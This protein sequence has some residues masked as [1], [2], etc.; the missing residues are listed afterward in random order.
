MRLEV[1]LGAALLP[2]GAAGG[3]EAYPWITSV[4]ALRVVARAGDGWAGE[5][6]QLALELDN[7]G[8]QASRLLRRSHRSLANVYRDDGSLYFRGTVQRVDPGRAAFILT[9]ESGGAGQLLSEPLPMRTTR[10]LGDYATAVPIPQ[11]YGDLSARRFRLIRLNATEYLAAGHPMT[12]LDVYVDDEETAAYELDLL[13]DD[14]G[15]VSQLVRFAAPLGTNQTASATGTGKRN[16]RTG[17]LIENPADL[18]EDVLAQAGVTALFPLLRQQAAAEGLRLAGSITEPRT[19]RAIVDEIMASAGAIWTPEFARLYP[20]STIAGPIHE[21]DATAAGGMDDPYSDLE[22]TADVLRVAYDFSEAADRPQHHLELSASPQR[23]GGLAAELELPWVWLPANAES[24][25]SRVLG[26]KAGERYRL[27]R[28][29]V[30]RDD[31]RPGAAVRLV[32]VPEWAVDDSD[33]VVMVL[34]VDVD[35]NTGA[36]RIAGETVLSTPAIRV[37]AVSI[38]LPD[39][40]KGGVDVRIVNG[41]ATFTALDDDGKPL[42]GA[43][44]TLD[45]VGPRTVNDKGEA[46]FAIVGGKHLLVIEREGFGLIE[47]E[48]DS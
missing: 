33:P 26:F 21:L 18:A 13:R 42:Y 23:Y 46:S 16:P 28:I 39:T 22:D 30:N 48:F 45:G 35:G 8:G 9:L 6:A 34:S 7:T 15:N 36:T 17:A 11:R 24:I 41:L 2:F 47:H 43:R 31:L 1:Q 14:A 5:T 37:T 32:D 4:G 3:T 25:G 10:E 40:T 19:V 44:M 29:T 38:A 20:A 12:I 27:P